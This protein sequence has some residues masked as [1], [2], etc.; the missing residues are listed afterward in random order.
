MSRDGLVG[1]PDQLVEK[2]ATYLTVG[3]SRVYLQVLDFD[4]LDQ[5]RLLARE[6]MP[7][8]A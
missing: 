7:A 1:T 8:V 4:D 2:I 3:V 6:V 5:V